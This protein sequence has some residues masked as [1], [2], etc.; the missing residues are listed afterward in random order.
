MSQE[1][2]N[3]VSV[4]WKWKDPWNENKEKRKREKKIKVNHAKTSRLMN[5]PIIFMQ[6]LLDKQWKYP[7]MK[8][9]SCDHKSNQNLIIQKM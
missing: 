1:R 2:K 3:E 5:S 4:G 7:K 8:L 9:K 6:R